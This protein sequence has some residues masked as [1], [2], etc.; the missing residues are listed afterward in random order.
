MKRL[1]WYRYSLYAAM[2]WIGDAWWR[3]MLVTVAA[4]ILI[5]WAAVQLDAWDRRAC[6]QRGGHTVKEQIWVPQYTMIGN[7]MV[8]TGTTREI[9]S[10]C[11]ER[12]K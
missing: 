9:V 3:V 8:H 5:A 12:S 1:P 2:D 10:H 6:M 11:E 4:V 7:Q